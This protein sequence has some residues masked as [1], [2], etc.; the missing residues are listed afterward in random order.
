MDTPGTSREAVS[1]IESLSGSP[2]MVGVENT[3]N[4]RPIGLIRVAKPHKF[5]ARHQPDDDA[6]ES[7]TL[8]LFP[9]NNYEQALTDLAG[10]SRI[11]LLW[12]FHRNDTWKPMV[13]PPRGDGTKRGVF[14][15]RS[16]HRPCPLGMTP[17]RLLG[18]TGRTLR[19]GPCD[20]VD[21]TPVFDIKPYVPAYDAFPGESAGWIDTVDA[22]E[23]ATPGHEV[24][25]SPTATEQMDWL[26][27]RGVGD[28]R[29]RLREILAHDP[30]PHRT[31]RI[32]KR[33]E[34]G[35]E[36]GCG[37]WRVRFTLESTRVRLESIAP[38]YGSRML[39]D[40]ARQHVPDREL[41][42]AFLDRWP[43]A[44]SPGPATPPRPPK[45]VHWKDRR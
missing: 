14:A 9:G 29:P 3:L 36:I 27:A 44:D 6:A 30:S 35:F 43:E 16:P 11:W 20:L 38:G 21:G 15:T 8:E 5:D 33:A 28:F 17:V 25:W 1:A 39:D 7:A 12:W 2:E 45:P 32:R 42:R 24:S 10:F 40:P 22:A 31:R 13:R 18:V 26:V 34:G 23:S 4:L 41:Q 19:L 37:V